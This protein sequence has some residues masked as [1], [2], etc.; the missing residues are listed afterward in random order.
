ML[1][2][3]GG[4]HEQ[5][6]TADGP[7]ERAGAGGAGQRAGRPRRAVLRSARPRPAGPLPRAS[8][9]D[10]LSDDLTMPQFTA[11]LTAEGLE[12]LV[13]VGLSRSDMRKL[14]AAGTPVPRPPVVTGIIDTGS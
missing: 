7:L 14:Q 3:G 11:S 2:S 13:M 10:H 6:R 1:A 5:S 9:S 4:R 8:P 12:L